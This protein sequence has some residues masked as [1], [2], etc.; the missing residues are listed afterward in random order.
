MTARPSGSNGFNPLRPLKLP[1]RS[2]RQCPAP[3]VSACHLDLRLRL[4]PIPLSSRPRVSS[5]HRRCPIGCARPGRCRRGLPRWAARE[6]P[7]GDSRTAHSSHSHCRHSR[8]APAH[9]AHTRQC[10][11]PAPSRPTSC[12]MRPRCQSGCARQALA[13]RLTRSRQHIN[14]RPAHGWRRPRLSPVGRSLRPLSRPR[15]RHF[16]RRARP[17]HLPPRAPSRPLIRR[18]RMG[19]DQLSKAALRR[20][21]SSTPPHCPRGW[22]ATE[23]RPWAVPER[24]S[25]P[26]AFRRNRCWMSRHCHS[27]CAINPPPPPRQRRRCSPVPVHRPRLAVGV[28]RSHQS[29]R[30]PRRS[31]PRPVGERLRAYLARRRSLPTTLLTRVRCQTGCARKGRQRGL[32]R[33][34]PRRWQAQRQR[35]IATRQ[36]TS[37]HPPQL[38]RLRAPRRAARPLRRPISLTRIPCHNGCAARMVTAAQASARRRAGR[39]KGHPR[40]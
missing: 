25:M 30:C 21:R 36:C 32:S 38:S 40:R 7:H 12:S 6:A 34:H 16:H 39:A 9:R 35:M 27:G 37:P 8:S 24:N 10:P 3:V 11:T 17:R 19:V 5:T 31:H 18:A 4:H 26:A 23:R 1:R 20:I 29:V 33:R 2:S 14:P 22:A 13:S 28:S 15:A